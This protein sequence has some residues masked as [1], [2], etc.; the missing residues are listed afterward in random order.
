M[1]E[2]PENKRQAI[3]IDPLPRWVIGFAGV[4]GLGSG[5][6]AVFTRDVEAGPVALL[7]IGALFFLIGIAGVLP[8]RLKFGDNEAEWLEAV[9]DAFGSVIEAVPAENLPQVEMAIDEL[10]EKA[11]ALANRARETLAVEQVLL[12]RVRDAAARV[13]AIITIEPLYVPGGAR[14][15][16]VVAGQNGSKVW[17]IAHGRG[18]KAWE[19]AAA[20]MLL[21]SVKALDERFAGVLVVS[22]ARDENDRS[23]TIR[24]EGGS[25]WLTV[26]RKGEDTVDI[27][28]ALREA[29]GPS[30]DDE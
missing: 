12:G 11:P 14:P 9:G 30:S 25:V 19:L 4:L 17:V 8:T 15:D 13:G 6:A 23:R 26:V 5:G 2:K 22:V 7:A 20:K 28:N 3:K 29:F 24:A 27:D 21:P 1:T 18:L 10:S 16:A